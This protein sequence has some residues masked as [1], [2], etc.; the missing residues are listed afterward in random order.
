MITKNTGDTKVPAG[1]LSASYG[2]RNTQ[3]YS[4]EISGK[5]GPV[6]YYL[7]AGHQDSD[8]LRY[9]RNFNNDDFFAKINIPVSKNV[10]LGFS[11]GYSDL[12]IK[13][14]V[15]QDLNYMG[16]IIARAFFVTGFIDATL[17]REL[18]LK[19]SL[20]TNRQ[21]GI[22]NEGLINPETNLLN[23][24]YDNNTTGENAKLVWTHG[25]HTAVIGT[26]IIHSSLDQNVVVLAS[27]PEVDKWAVF[28]ND[29]I[30]LGKLTITPGIRYD[31][32]NISGSFVS[33]SLGITYKLG[34][35]SVARAS[36]ARGF[37]YPN[38]I[39]TKIGDGYYL[40]P[41]PDLKPEEV[42]SY[43]AGLESNITDYILA[44][45]TVFYHDMKDSMVKEYYA[46]NGPPGC[47]GDATT[48]NPCND[49]IVNKG[50]TRR[51]G[52]ELEAETVPFYN[53][54]FKGGIAYVET[55]PLPES[56]HTWKYSYNLAVKYDDR[57]SFMAQLWGTY[58]WFI[59]RPDSTGKYNDFI[60]D[61][62]LQKKIY[63]TDKTKTE[64]FLTAHNIFNASQYDDSLYQN[65]RRWVE[66]GIR[67]K[68]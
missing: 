24:I 50:N 8:G 23:K 49:L 44:K 56:V 61:I 37:S 47:T 4:A 22:V 45:A 59:T 67:F 26:D 31:Q 57:K 10:T 5:A 12:D 3:D 64:L 51:K 11:S 2:E 60:W 15:S 53:V 13:S 35:H 6:G 7:F 41:N 20:Y 30:N 34:E 55:D 54:S 38:L 68:F 29:S 48:P 43:Q 62:N 66:A 18:S 33:P 40:D 14:L 52:F 16:K 65:P 9:N 19:L 46:S 28:A 27:R 39:D 1:T 17:T 36:V 63:S 42:W 25:M 21:R 58:K 32:N